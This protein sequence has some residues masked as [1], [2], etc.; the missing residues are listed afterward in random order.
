MGGTQTKSGIVLHD[1]TLLFQSSVATPSFGGRQKLLDHL[2][3]IAGNLHSSAV[4][5]GYE[6]DGLGIA[7]AGWVDAGSGTVA[8]ATDNLP[9]WTGT[10]IADELG[11]CINLPVAVENDAN[12]FALAEKRFGAGRE[13]TDFISITL[14]TGVGGGCFVGNRL[15]RGAHSFAN[16]LGHISIE[17]DGMA[18]TCGQKGCL[19][20]YCNSAAFLH[21]ARGGFISVEQLISAVNSGNEQAKSALEIFVE[22]L[23]RGC[24]I[25]LQL[26]DPQALILAGGLTQNNPQLLN[27]LSHRLA[28]LVPAW[29][30]RKLTVMASPLGYHGGVL[31]AAA[32]ALERLSQFSDPVR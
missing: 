26:F 15:N 20:A 18:C 4:K 16:A 22:Y 30:Q 12:A 23:A 5:H 13:L 7:T 9:G 28:G 32:I 14:G 8:Y 19:E 2:K 17:R 21:Y 6:P 11:A 3:Q 31:G 10:R 29:N 24:S 25:L 27:G 1:G